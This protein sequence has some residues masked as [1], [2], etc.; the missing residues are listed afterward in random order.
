MID[1]PFLIAHLSRSGSTYLSATLCRLA[2]IFILP[3]STFFSRIY[4]WGSQISSK[5]KLK[6]A[7]AFLFEE[8]KFVDLDFRPEDLIQL[9]SEFPI[10][11]TEF[12]SVITRSTALRRGDH[13]K[14]IGYKKGGEIIDRLPIL[15]EQ[16]PGLQVIWLLRDVRGIYNSQKNQVMSSGEPFTRSLRQT[17]TEWNNFVIKASEAVQL[18][19]STDL[20]IRYE[21]FMRTPNETVERVCGFL[22]VTPYEHPLESNPYI[23]PERYGNLHEDALRGPQIDRLE[24]WR[25]HLTEGEIEELESLLHDNLLRFGYSV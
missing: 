25:N 12:S 13:F 4:D 20:L 5:E 1:S 11:C 8:S 16:L 14:R 17:A 3:E 7:V 6:E 19:P 2:P 24:R 9:F 21:D 15:R 23:I 18:N 22:E 10:S